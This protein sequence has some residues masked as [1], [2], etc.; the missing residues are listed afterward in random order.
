MDYI[1][2]ACDS[3]FG[4]ITLIGPI[5]GRTW[6]ITKQGSWILDEFPRNEKFLDI[7]CERYCFRTRRMIKQKPIFLS[8][9]DFD[10]LM[11][12]PNGGN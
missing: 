5:S 11:S 7:E 8:T 6:S 1:F 2:V 3:K 10:Q 9:P 4:S 12:M